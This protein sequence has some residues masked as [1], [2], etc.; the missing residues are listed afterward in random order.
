MSNWK[1]LNN[2][3]YLKATGSGR[4]VSDYRHKVQQKGWSSLYAVSAA[5][6][7]TTAEWKVSIY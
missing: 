4:A 2:F 7:T 5:D 1:G 3:R 6:L